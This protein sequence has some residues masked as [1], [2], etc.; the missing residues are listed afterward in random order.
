[1]P[2][3]DG[4]ALIITLDATGG[5]GAVDVLVDLYTAWKDW[6]KEP[7]VGGLSNLRFPQAFDPSGGEELTPGIKAGSYSRIRNDLGWRIRP[8]EEHATILFTGNLVPADSSL[9]IAIPTLGPYTV[10]MPGLQPI[11]QSVESL[12]LLQ[13]ETL[14]NGVVHVDL[15]DG[16]P[17]TNYPV[18]TASEP[19][20]TMADARTIAL[21]YGIREL[22][23]R[24]ILL[25]DGSVDNFVL[26]GFGIPAAIDFNGFTANG[27]KLRQL[28]ATGDMAGT[29]G[30]VFEQCNIGDL[31]DVSASFVDCMF[32][33][34]TAFVPPQPGAA[35][36][37]GS[38]ASFVAGTATPIFDLQDLAQDLQMRAWSGGAE[39]RNCSQPTNNI[40]VDMLSGYLKLDASCTAGTIVVRG[41]GHLTDN[42]NGATV[43][44]V[45]LVSPAYVADAV[46]DELEVDHT[47]P[48]SMGEKLGLIP[49]TAVTHTRVDQ[50]WTNKSATELV[51]VVVLTQDTEPVTLPPTARLSVEIR[52]SAGTLVASKTNIAPNT[53]G[54]FGTTI[55]LTI[56]AGNAFEAFAT[57]TDGPNTYKSNVGLAVPYI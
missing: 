1:M 5:V 26:E 30:A 39:I 46:W 11:T 13:Q 22:H 6:L 19:A 52:D 54:W 40:S 27:S 15:L 18:G 29:Q 35:N 53:L 9:P 44:T 49:S 10:L 57:I 31:S 34:T 16:G 4:E 38:C 36:F 43:V 3:F 48:G 50:N 47:V 25:L 20:L 42:S 33:G 28:A 2:V 24:G 23:G 56:A 17:G 55:N 41:V 32:S 8:F 37:L 14:Y 21:R 7:R 45:G 51:G 12:L